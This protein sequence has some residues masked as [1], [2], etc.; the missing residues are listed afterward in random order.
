[1]T[2]KSKKHI[3]EDIDPDQ[4]F[5]DSSNLPSF[6]TDQLEGILERPISKYSF[7]VMGIFF[8]VLILVFAGRATYLQ[9]YNGG[10]FAI[11]SQ[12]NSLKRVA[13]ATP[14]GVIYDRNGTPLAWNDN[15]D[16]AYIQDS[17][18]AHLIGYI[19]YPTQDEVDNSP[20]TTA[21]DMIGK[22]G[23]E[24]QFNDLLTGVDGKKIAEV[25]AK[26]EVQSEY[27]YEP[28]VPGKNLN[29]SVDAD[30]SKEFYEAIKKLAADYKFKGGAG[31]IMDIKTGE[32][33]AMTSFPEY[34][35]EVLSKG[36][37]HQAIANYLNDPSMP[38]LNRAISGL[39]T[40]GSIVKPI[41]ALAA[42]NEG[43][44]SPE[45]K[46][47]SIGYISIPN[48]FFPDKQSI[49]KDW[50]AQGWVDMRR[51][52]SVSSDVYFYEVGG[53]YQDQKGLGITKLD[54]YA[55]MFGLGT[56]T[57]MELDGEGDGNIPTPEWKAENFNGDKW[58]IGDTY[59]SSIGQYGFLVTPIQMA[60]VAAAI[61]T[62]GHLIKPTIFKSPD[63][64]AVKYDQINIPQDMFKVVQ[65]GMREG[66]TDSDGTA[67]ALNLAEVKVA[68]KTGTAELGI[69]K[70][71]VNAWGVGFFPYDN[72]RYSYALVM[73]KGSRDNA[74]G[75]NAAIRQLLVW[76]GQNTPEYPK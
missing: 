33:I 45:K 53:G 6:D 64:K 72:P 12:S 55:A 54:Q 66:V 27:I 67:R 56:S 38:F 15:N 61:A 2:R 21:M 46:I 24:K 74:V 47:L 41:F 49:F 62:D 35:P 68:S 28:G 42:L 7:L 4:I 76:M 31:V 75:A 16:R 23:V 36:D 34:E 20:T 5:L 11:R 39:Y 44:I 30:V 73:E 25:N 43:I 13:V 14:R 32:V 57:G 8:A 59:I 18:L 17:G 19:G 51:A 52:L 63:G 69:T 40:P 37:D 9:A 70:K 10:Y 29:L 3:S 60:R 1:M 48:P 50:R 58:R 22:A 65:E 26:G 71:L